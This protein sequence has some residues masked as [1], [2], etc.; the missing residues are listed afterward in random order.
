M[1]SIFL[2]EPKRSKYG[3]W[4]FDDESRG[5]TNEPFVGE[6]NDLIDAM[7]RESGYEI[8]EGLRIPLMFALSKYPGSQ[9]EL[10]LLDTSPFGSTYHSIE[11][12]LEPWLCPAFFKYFPE[13]PKQFFASVYPKP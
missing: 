2:L 1:N 5:L 6:T 9:T 10:A 4:S 3:I 7:A 13:A 11:Y 12:D 8:I